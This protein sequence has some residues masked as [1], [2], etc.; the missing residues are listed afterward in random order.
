MNNT[1]KILNTLIEIIRKDSGI[2][3]TMDAMEQ[4]SAILIL[5]HFYKVVFIDSF[6]ENKR[7]DFKNIFKE[8]D[9]FNKEKKQ[10][11]FFKF[12]YLIEN[13]F[14]NEENIY[15]RNKNWNKIESLLENIPFKI[16]SSKILEILL[17][18]IED[19]EFNDKL[20]ES[21]EKL[22]EKMANE[23]SGSGAFHSPKAVVKT[24]VKIINPNFGQS[25]YD[26]SIGTGG[27]LIEAQKNILKN[28]LDGNS[29]E[30]IEIYGENNS[31]FSS[32]VAS[33]N[34]QLNGIDIKNIST[35]H[36]LFEDND[37]TF[38]IILSNPPF[39]KILSN[40]KHK[41]NKREYSLNFETMFLKTILNKLSKNGKSA[42]IV[43]DGFLFN[44]S[45]EF[46]TLREELLIKYNLHS[47]ISLPTGVF[48]PY[49]GIKVSIL[50]FD[51]SIIEDDIWFYELKTDKPLSKSNKIEEKDFKELI[52]LFSKRIKSQNSCLVKKQDIL[53]KKDLNLKIEIPKKTDK[54]R[55]LKISDEIL[56]LEEKK[57]EFNKLVLEFSSLIEENKKANFQETVTLGELFT[58]KSGKFLKRE[59]IKDEGEYPVYGGNGIRGYYDKYN[60]EG[61]NIIIGRV[62]SYCGNIH[63]TNK[64]IWVENNAFSIN[65]N[66]SQKVYLP[67]LSHVLRSLDLNKQARGSAQP[68]I[69]YAKIKDI[70]IDLPSYEQQIE[71]NNWFEKIEKQNNDLLKLVEV[72][73]KRFNELSKILIVNN[74]I[75]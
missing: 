2:N 30:S 49:S 44:T 11:D 5:K 67:Y 62:G 28:R 26:P 35:K 22:L 59:E 19:I 46:L 29:Q 13:L 39:G 25:I 1:E 24:M 70:K 6:E 63:F 7:I 18:Y 61:E 14:K 15:L 55:N 73:S 33:L 4:L 42:I 32:L 57:E 10:T 9:Y 56:I 16:R 51:N 54:Q 60:H 58:I 71:L 36:T 3:N 38:D 75:K 45:N 47:I 8:L 17:S 74:C 64:P 20:A 72:Q 68:S 43:P 48:L 21:Y 50:F 52:K 37:S 31:D 41:D 53:N 23:S 34:L 40:I 66:L 69:S 65:I 27:F 12:K